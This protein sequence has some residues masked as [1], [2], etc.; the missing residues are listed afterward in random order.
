MDVCKWQESPIPVSQHRLKE[1]T[2]PVS[3]QTKGITHTSIPTQTKGI[4]HTSI[5]TQITQFTG[6]YKQASYIYYVIVREHVSV[7]SSLR[8]LSILVYTLF[9]DRHRNI[10]YTPHYFRTPVYWL[11]SWNR[12]S[13]FQINLI[14]R[15]N[16]LDTK[17][18]KHS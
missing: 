2:I 15:N 9:L 7:S 4:T 18:R 3:T 14:G 12:Q 6:Y 17:E 13:T 1:S 16:R 5:P 11:S 10:L 8:G